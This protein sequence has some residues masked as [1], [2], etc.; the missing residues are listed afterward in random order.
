MGIRKEIKRGKIFL[1][2]GKISYRQNFG[3]GGN[4][5]Q[6]QIIDGQVPVTKPDWSV[7][8]TGN[9]RHGWV[10]R[11]VFFKAKILF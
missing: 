2:K 9:P 3:N 4:C 8:G 6:K 7:L 10:S 5:E 11:T 1:H